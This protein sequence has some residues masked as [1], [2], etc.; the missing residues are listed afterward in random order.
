MNAALIPTNGMNAAF[1]AN[2]TREILRARLIFS[3]PRDV[4]T[5]TAWPSAPV[6]S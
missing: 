1:I 2:D 5:L 3:A 6:P 4:P